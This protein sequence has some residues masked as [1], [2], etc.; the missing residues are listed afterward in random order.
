M[1]PVSKQ[2]VLNLLSLSKKNLIFN[3]I[4]WIVLHEAGYTLTAICIVSFFTRS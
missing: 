4:T 3:I 2:N 1:E